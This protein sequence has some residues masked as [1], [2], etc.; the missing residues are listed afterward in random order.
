MMRNALVGRGVRVIATGA[1]VM[2]LAGAISLSSET[3]ALTRQTAKT[4]DRDAMVF[5]AHLDPSRPN[6]RLKADPDARPV[7]PLRKGKRPLFDSERVFGTG[8]D[9]EPVVAADPVDPRYV[10][11]AVTRFGGAKA[12]G[13]CPDPAI[14]VRTSADAGVS[15]GPDVFLCA[16]PGVPGQ[17]DP[18]LQVADDG[19]VYAAW[20]DDWAISFAKSFDRGQTWT[21]PVNVDG[22]GNNSWYADKPWMAIS[23]D[24]EDVYIAFNSQ[25]SYVAVSHDGGASF[26]ARIQN[27]TGTAPY[28]YAEGGAVAPN[29]DVYI[30]ESGDTGGGGTSTQLALLRSSDEGATWTRTVLDTS[31][32]GSDGFFFNAQ[33]SVD[34][35]PEGT[36]VFAYVHTP[37]KNAAKQLYVRTS[38]DGTNWTPRVQVNAVGD[39]N[40]PQVV[41]GPVAGVFRVAWMDNREGAA[42]WNTYY[43]RSPN[44]GST[45]RPEKVLSN[46]GSGASYKT[47]LGFTYPYGDYFDL[48]VNGVGRTFAIWGEGPSYAGPG[49]AWYTR[50][51]RTTE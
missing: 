49:G 41:A 37:T 28:W 31:R 40:Y 32:Y 36:I 29:G 2:V 27:S 46:L 35:D 20:M 11:Q 19:T 26:G 34:V 21:A 17:A 44:A 15:W 48:D 1:A 8:D 39:S 16:C 13:T 3:N 9:W 22:G 7:A 14:I 43:S 47:T 51:R 45:W 12:C 25:K 18:L 4:V 10:Y 6:P 42:A 5:A 23:G 38:T 33:A 24:G 50:S 30:A